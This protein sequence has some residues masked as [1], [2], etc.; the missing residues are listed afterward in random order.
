MAGLILIV[1][2]SLMAVAHPILMETV[3]PRGIYH[4]EVGY[5]INAAPWPSPPSFPE[6]VLGVDGAGRDVF[7]QL[8]ASTRPSFT[9]AIAAALATA[10]ISTLLGALGAYF[11]GP[12]DAIFSN[13]SDALL[14]IPVPIVMVLIGGQYYDQL[15]A[16]EFGLL[17]GLLAGASSAAIVMRSHAI[18]IM[19]SPY[20][21]AAR[22]SG[23]GP[24]HIITR[25]LIP[26]MLPLVAVHMM[27]TVT[28]GVVAHGFVTFLG[29]SS[30]QRLNWGSM[31]Y[32]AINSIG[33]RAD[34]Q[35]ISI[36]V[37]TLCLSLFAAAFY[38][39][40]RGLQDVSDPR[41]RG[42]R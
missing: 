17:Y 10:V 32:N 29:L 42:N 3:W 15:S 8:L 18:T 20:I 36:M 11:R 41:L 6:H 34:I 13:I 37:P 2:F 40:G 14:L 25:H 12:V 28:G 21:E 23:S 31:I 5:D 22:V 7:S 24:W 19:N 30:G 35:W 4:P 27:V 1:F 9:V 26:H 33:F 16:L 39:V 38:F